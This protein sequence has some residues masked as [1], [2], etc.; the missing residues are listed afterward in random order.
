MD[1]STTTLPLEKTNLFWDR[2]KGVI[3]VLAAQVFGVLMN[4]TTRLLELEGN[5][6]AGMHPF[7]VSFFRNILESH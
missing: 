3:Y 4:L 7:Q 1:R 6:G 5:H 2:N